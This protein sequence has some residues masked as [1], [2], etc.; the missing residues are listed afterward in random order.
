MQI[1]GLHPRSAESKTL[2]VEPSYL[3]F[4][5]PLGDS[6]THL[7]GTFENHCLDLTFTF[8]I[9][10]ELHNNLVRQTKLGYWSLFKN[11]ETEAQGSHLTYLK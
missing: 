11:G 1:I 10:F 3:S 7:S 9:L 5:Y 8:L 6:N 2:G 4:T